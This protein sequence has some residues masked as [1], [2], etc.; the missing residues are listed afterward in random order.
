[1][2]P[3]PSPRQ[4][5]VPPD[6]LTTR[7]DR[8]LT[9]Q[10]ADLSRARIQGLI[11][12]GFILRNGQPCRGR[13]SVRPGDSF[14][15]T[16]PEPEPSGLIAQAIPLT[17]VYEDDALL[18]VDKPKGLVVHPAP[19][20]SDGTLVN[21][22]LARTGSLSSINGIERPGIV[23]RLD[24]DTTGLLVV[25]KTDHAH[26]HLQGQIQN[27]TAHRDYLAVIHGQPAQDR[28]TIDAPIGRHPVHR[29]KM[30]VT[31]KGRE[32]RTDWQV[33]ERLGNYALLKFSLST[34]RTHQIR[35]HS[36]HIGHPIV[37]DELYS[38]AKSPVNL[39]G[40]A[41][42][43]YQ[44]SFDHPVSGERLSFEAPLPAEMV[45]L[46]SVARRH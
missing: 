41:L 37:G 16:I 31:A 45:K 21:A 11:D 5:T 35:V 33:V 15:V 36:A 30:A 23:H 46:L 27:K 26:Q 13:D 9:D 6:Q 29:Q 40:Q 44:L 14:T 42:H 12:Q 8:W 24:K 43:A 17:I 10:L 18:V 34:G 32:A 1:M 38:S 20:H 28:G 7:L 4:L 39:T 3:L 22:L 19:G 2:Q 25:A